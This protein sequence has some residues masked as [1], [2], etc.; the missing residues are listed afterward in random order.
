[1]Y[2]PQEYTVAI[3]RAYHKY[4]VEV[5]DIW[6]VPDYDLLLQPYTDKDFGQYCKKKWTQLMWKF[7]AVQV[8]EHFPL[9]CK[10]TYRKY[11]QDEAIIIRK[12]EGEKCGFIEEY[13]KICWFP[14]ELE[15]VK[16]DEGV[17]TQEAQ[18]AGFF[19]LQRLPD[20]RVIRPQGFR[21]GGIDEFRKT[22][23]RVRKELPEKNVA[24]W[25]EFA[26]FAPDSDDVCEY[27]VKNPEA[28]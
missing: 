1:M 14:E 26:A 3:K 23:K 8:S 24:E 5:I 16:N 18:H 12:K 27:M 11:T 19:L 13:C 9:G 25:E 21:A 6:V 7:E 28:M 20:E 17:V 4:Q 15:E 22:L 10:T 2:S